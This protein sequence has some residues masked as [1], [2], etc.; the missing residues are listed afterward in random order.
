MSQP[1]A[2]AIR[3]GVPMV[4]QAKTSRFYKGLHLLYPGSALAVAG[5]NA[6]TRRGALQ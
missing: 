2:L 5:P 3:E 4:E 6:R 1:H